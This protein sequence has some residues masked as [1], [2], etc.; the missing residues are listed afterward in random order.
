MTPTAVAQQR[1]VEPTLFGAMRRHW[2][3]V[4][5]MVVACVELALAFGLFTQDEYRASA[6]VS[7]ARP[8]GSAVQSDAQYLDSQVLLLDSRR[9]GDRA[10]EIARSTE[11]GAGIERAQLVPTIGQVEI[12][13]PPSQTSASYGTTIVTIQF[14]APIPEEAQ[15]GANA[16]ATAYDEVRSEEIAASA[17]ARL[18]GIDR[19]IATTDSPGDLASLRKERVQALIDQS[20]DL[21][22]AVSMSAADEPEAPAGSGPL[23]LL[24]VGLCVG[25][26]AGGAAAYARADRLGHVGETPVAARLYGAPLLW[27]GPA[28][29]SSAELTER[30]R[31]LGRAVG[32]SM[33]RLE[34]CSALAV[35]ASPRNAKR[36]EA[37]AHLALALAER[38]AKVFAV[39]GGDETMAALLGPGTAVDGSGRA[40][41]KTRESALPRDLSV[42]DLSGPLPDGWGSW[43]DETQDR[44]VVVDC[45]TT[46]ARGVDLL[47][48]SDAVLVLVR[49]DEPVGDHV[50][51]AR[52][53]QITGTEVLGYVFTPY[54]P[55]GPRPWLRRR[56]ARARGRSAGMTASLPTRPPL[57]ARIGH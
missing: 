50:A 43:I 5:V 36:S 39:D 48:R 34:G 24:G 49:A 6:T 47:S 1:L 56:R 28:G 20:R 15:I 4:S 55:R 42:V 51:I 7:A 22:Q 12:I 11:A 19:A 23:A 26:V 52:W 57:R 31:L 46:S 44:V 32:Q 17:E 21:S 40:L 25:L 3:L 33:E 37:S 8:A 29:T 16:L 14:T 45:P 35:V 27:K 13:P 2:V 41:G 53:L 9:V 30:D 10:F 38:G 54:T 18:E